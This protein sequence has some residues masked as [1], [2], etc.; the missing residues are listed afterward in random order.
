MDIKVRCNTCD[1]CNKD[2]S[3]YKS[4]WA[5][6]KKFHS[7]E[8]SKCIPNEPKSTPNVL[9][10]SYC[11]KEFS[12]RQNRWKHE[13]KVCENKKILDEKLKKLDKIDILEKEIQ[14]LKKEKTKE[15][16]VNNGTINNGTIN[17]IVI[18]NYNEDNIDYITDKFKYLILNMIPQ[19]Q[20]NT[21]PKLLENVKFNPNHK[22][23]NN[24]KIKSDRSKI[25]WKYQDNEWKAANK[26][27]SLWELLEYGNKLLKRF[28]DEK[29]ETL[30]DEIK[31][32]YHDF[33]DSIVK[34]KKNLETLNKN[35]NILEKEIIGT[36][37]N[38][39]YL[40]TKNS[41]NILDK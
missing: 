33:Q 13:K 41:E 10:C 14:I 23:N 17:N 24:F 5:H 18:N 37:E 3:S 11:K 6:N 36:I 30:N 16:N 35:E 7:N 34:L 22:E 4:L 27:K 31:E 39:A 2:Y 15:T 8:G 26:K 21:I 25:C 40:Y 1:I 38:I 19:D 9:I 29:K 12:S 28:Y 20:V 32:K